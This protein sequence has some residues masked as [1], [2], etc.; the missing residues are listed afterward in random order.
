[1]GWD[2]NDEMMKL[3]ALVDRCAG[4]AGLGTCGCFIHRIEGFEE[5][6]LFGKH[7]E[8]ILKMPYSKALELLRN[9]TIAELVETEVAIYKLKGV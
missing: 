1:M 9:G 7:Y 5:F 3:V 8:A 4:Y 6:I 2:K